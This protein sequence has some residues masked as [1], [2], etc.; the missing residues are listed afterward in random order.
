MST[1]YFTNQ[2]K[3]SSFRNKIPKS[4]LVENK[5]ERSYE[6]VIAEL[7]IEKEINSEGRVIG[8][9]EELYDYMDRENLVNSKVSSKLRVHI[10]KCLYKFVESK[11]EQIL[12]NIAKVILSVST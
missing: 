3:D 2:L 9:L 1:G 10:L 6:D 4:I 8:L 7:N 5:K 11:N 12:I